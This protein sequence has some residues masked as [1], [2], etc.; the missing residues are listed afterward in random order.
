MTTVGPFPAFI[1]SA[2]I[3]IRAGA[4]RTVD[5][6][7]LNVTIRAAPALI[8]NTDAVRGAGGIDGARWITEIGLFYTGTARI[9]D[10]T[11]VAAAAFCSA[12][13]G[14]TDLIPALRFTCDLATDPEV[15]WPPLH[16][17]FR[18]CAP[19][20]A[21][22]VLDETWAP[23]IIKHTEAVF[24]IIPGFVRCTLVVQRKLSTGHPIRAGLRRVGT[25]P[26]AVSLNLFYAR[27][28]EQTRPGKTLRSRR[29]CLTRDLAVRGPLNA[30]VLRQEVEGLC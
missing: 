27:V 11:R 5:V 2:E 1:T 26:H 15:L 6:A 24:W 8:T 19:F 7:T 21:P 20:R 22:I 14:A 13:V 4:V 16:V 28:G 17:F 25:H 12:A 18:A 3:R 23:D 10:E 9:T 30:K 29:T